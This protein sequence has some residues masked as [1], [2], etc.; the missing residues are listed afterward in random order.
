M[1]F[2]EFGVISKEWLAFI[3][4]NPAAAQDGLNGNDPLQASELRHATNTTREIASAKLV[5]ESGLR[6][7]VDISTLYIT[8]RGS[9]S[10]P[11]R[12]YLPRSPKRESSLP[13]IIYF[14]GGGFLFGSESTD[15]FLCANIA[16]SLGVIGLSVI[17]RH[18]PEFQHP[19]Q[20]E[21]AWDAMA[22]IEGHMEALNIDENAGLGVL[23]GISAGSG[24]AAGVVFRDLEA[25]RAQ[26][27]REPMIRSAVLG[28]PWL[29]HVEKYPFHFF[30]SPE[31]AAKVR[32]RDAPVIPW[33]MLKLFSDIL[34]A[35]DPSDPLLNIA[36][37]PDELLRRWP[38]T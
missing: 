13:A 23:L 32:C 20:H 33:G 16:A 12:Q 37:L 5:D 4:E 29:R 21:D 11:L 3:A 27:D 17:Y 7:K 1:D 36:T 9:H 25:S 28:I 6:E 22:Y 38:R 26:P 19:A 30:S 35:K 31:I 10:T 15:D 34:S 2:S 8:S 24:L 18:T 14:H